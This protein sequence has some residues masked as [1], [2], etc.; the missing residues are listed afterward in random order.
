MVPSPA[1]PADTGSWG[2]V[3]LGVSCDAFAVTGDG[4]LLQ[5]GVCSGEARLVGFELFVLQYSGRACMQREK[6]LFPMRACQQPIA[7]LKRRRTTALQRKRTRRCVVQP[8]A[9]LSAT[10]F[11][12]HQPAAALTQSPAAPTNEPTAEM[13]CTRS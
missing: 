11:G 13:V 6:W 4:M 10:D 8:R 2:T 12:V 5:A 3:R 1:D 9:A 7:E